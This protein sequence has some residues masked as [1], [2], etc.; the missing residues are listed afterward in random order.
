M[1]A[2]KLACL[3]LLAMLLISN[4]AQ[5]IT[6]NCNSGAAFNTGV[7][8][9]NAFSSAEK[10]LGPFTSW[11]SLGGGGLYADCYDWT[12]PSGYACSATTCLGFL[13][14]LRNGGCSTRGVWTANMIGKHHMGAAGTSCGWGYCENLRSP[15]VMTNAGDLITCPDHG[16]A[17]AAYGACTMGV[18]SNTVTRANHGLAVGDRIRFNGTNGG[19]VVAT[20][21]YVKTVPTTGTFTFSTSIGGTTFD[22]TGAEGSA[23]NV[24]RNVVRFLTTTAG[25]TA[26]IDYFVKTVPTVDTFTIS[27]SVGGATRDITADA[28]NKVTTRRYARPGVHYVPLDVANQTILTSDPIANGNMLGRRAANW[29]RYTNYI[30]QNYRYSGSQLYKWNGSSWVAVSDFDNTGATYYDSDLAVAN[31]I[32]WDGTDA[33]HH[34]IT[35]LLLP[36]NDPNGSTPKAV[37]WEIGN[38]P[39]VDEMSGG[40]VNHGLTASEY[41]DRYH[42]ITYYMLQADPTIQVGPC[43]CSAGG[44]SAAYLTDIDGAGDPMNFVAYHPY[45]HL[46]ADWPNTTEMTTTLDEISPVMDLAR[47]YAA[48]FTNQVMATEWDPSGWN[49]NETLNPP[50]YV[51]RTMGHALAVAENILTFA[52]EGRSTETCKM[53][54]ANYWGYLSETS[55]DA[56]K[57]IFSWMAAT[58]GAYNTGFLGDWMCSNMLIDTGQNVRAYLTKWASGSNK[59]MYLW[60]LNFNNSGYVDIPVTFTNP[61]SAP[62]GFT[63][64]EGYL[65]GATGQLTDYV[66]GLWTYVYD[67]GLDPR[68][69]WSVGLSSA[70]VMVFV[71][72]PN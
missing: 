9:I 49:Y 20:T 17:V 27:T 15:C 36:M 68:T 31:S 57:M 1:R 8:G 10:D 25:V 69:G 48:T 19:V 52:K 62:N 60:L 55:P 51:H 42:Y 65:W 71:I 46:G 34:D 14:G 61:P 12:V 23:N 47:S 33:T 63:V 3:L 18:A 59:D 70:T 4:T 37:Y 53:I 2:I 6:F 11:R 26:N 66:P 41:G 35:K 64:S 44:G 50:N 56:Q 21:Y 5:A 40:I 32:L 67:T 58:G 13:T 39:E 29:V 30:V 22:I 16:L 43:L 54:A 45:Y 7:R 38:E 72:H 24:T 28:L